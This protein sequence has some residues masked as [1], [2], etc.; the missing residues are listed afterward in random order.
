MSQQ[1]EEKI[2]FDGSK[3]KVL[4]ADYEPGKPEKK[5]GAEEPGRDAG[6]PQ[7]GGSLTVFFIPAV[8]P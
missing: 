3:V 6:V 8:I 1:L 7:G 2:S 5:Y 4:G